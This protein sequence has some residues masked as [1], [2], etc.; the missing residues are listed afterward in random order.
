MINALT[1]SGLKRFV[2][3]PFAFAPLTILTGLNGSGKTTL[4][5]ALLLSREASADSAQSIRLNGPFGLQLGTAGDVQNWNS[6]PPIRIEI[7][8]TGAQGCRWSLEAPHDEALYL[9]VTERPEVL[10]L[11][12][13]GKPRAFTYLSAER[14]GPRSIQ[15]TSPVPEDDLEV[16]VQGE[17]CAHMLSE[18]GGKILEDPDRSHPDWLPA[19][20]RLLKYEVEQWLTEITRPI[21]IEGSRQGD[22]TVAEI[23]FRSPGG[24]WVRAPNMGFGVSYAL[25]IILAGLSAEAGGLLIVENPEAHLHPGGQSRMGV[26]LAWLAGRGVQVV[27][28]THSDHVLNGVRRAVAEH[29]YLAAGDAIAW[30]FG[31]DGPESSPSPPEALTFTAGGSI[32]DWPKGFFDQYQIDVSALG[33]NRRRT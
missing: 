6:A 12:Y 16:G 33:R 15:E 4:L 24:S 22:A 17:H 31:E 30:F 1:V 29:H 10:P 2:S 21:E 9:T 25:P 20:P 5:Q 28:E 3:E 14:L 32:S 13:S 23:R 19:E 26:F 8:A 18:M 7:D 27:V 11:A